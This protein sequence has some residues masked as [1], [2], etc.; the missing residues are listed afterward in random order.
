MKTIPDIDE[1]LTGF[2]QSWFAP[3][4]RLPLGDKD[5]LKT[6]QWKEDPKETD[7]IIQAKNVDNSETIGV[8]PLIIFDRAMS[9]FHQSSMKNRMSARITHNEE[10]F[11][12]LI[13]VPYV[14]HCISQNDY[15]ASMLATVVFGAFWMYRDWFRPLGYHKIRVDG[16]GSPAILYQEEAKTVAYDTPVRLTIMYNMHFTM[17]KMTDIVED[18]Q[19]GMII[20]NIG[21][22]DL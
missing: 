11:L 10:T 7:L 3:G 17:R 6:Y 5:N 2:L 18:Y 8:T 14:V 1:E 12:E 19:E 22:E 4:R 16:I 15:I 13:T 9:G 20:T 21:T